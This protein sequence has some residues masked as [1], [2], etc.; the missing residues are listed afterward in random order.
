MPNQRKEE[1]QK[2]LLDLSKQ[3][4]SV[5]SVP[6]SSESVHLFV[7]A[8]QATVTTQYQPSALPEGKDC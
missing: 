3:L 6:R 2:H 5:P 4:M 1:R 7:F 8:Y